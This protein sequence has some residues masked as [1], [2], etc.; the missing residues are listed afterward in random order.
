MPSVPGRRR[1]PRDTG[2]F[3]G[4]SLLEYT[5]HET[6]ILLVPKQDIEQE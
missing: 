1:A 4:E 3:M 2:K 5:G 6:A